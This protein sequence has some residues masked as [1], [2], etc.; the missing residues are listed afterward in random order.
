MF[1]MWYIIHDNRTS[2]A[3]T[4]N[5]LI[6]Y[7]HTLREGVGSWYLCRSRM[8]THDMQRESALQYK[9]SKHQF[10]PVFF[11]NTVGS[12]RV[13]LMDV[14]WC[15]SI[16]LYEIILYIAW[17]RTR[18]YRMAPLSLREEKWFDRNN[19]QQWLMVIQLD[20][21]SNWCTAILIY[22]VTILVYNSFQSSR[23]CWS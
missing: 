2:P 16:L 23:S 11:R 19:I 12:N 1:I 14:W 10:E 5:A 7:V 20:S 13:K 4:S 3:I 9:S 18:F 21:W 15:K 22:F 17:S 6:Y 8:E